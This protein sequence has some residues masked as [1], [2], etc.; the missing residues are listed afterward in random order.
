MYYNW[1]K[2]FEEIL[3]LKNS[4]SNELK[5]IIGQQPYKIKLK[6]V[7]FEVSSFIY[8]YNK[9][10]NSVAFLV[11]NWIKIQ[12]SLEMVFNLLFKNNINGLKA[13]CFLRENNVDAQQFAQYLYRKYSIILTNSRLSNDLDNM[14]NIKKL[15]KEIDKPTYFLLVG[16]IARKDYMRVMKDEKIQGVAHLI[17]PSGMVLNNG[18]NSNKYYKN[19]YSLEGDNDQ[20]QDVINKFILIR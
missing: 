13:L 9:L 14:K 4:D 3:K 12:D 16:D 10:G 1:E 5:V 19:W 20:E 7:N 2:D 17:H 8:P 15:V 18:R 6:D 11:T